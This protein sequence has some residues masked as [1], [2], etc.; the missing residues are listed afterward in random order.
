MMSK[1]DY[2]AMAEAIAKVY[3]SYPFASP[4]A[5]AVL[6]VVEKLS[7]SIMERTK[8]FDK[9]RFIAACQAKPK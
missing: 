8:R 5:Y 4:E 7:H 1:K 2:V 9:V 6:A 3:H